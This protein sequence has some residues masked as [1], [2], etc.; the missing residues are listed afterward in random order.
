MCLQVLVS[1]SQHDHSIVASLS[2]PYIWVTIQCIW[3]LKAIEDKMAYIW[4]GVWEYNHAAQRFYG[5]NGFVK[6][7]SHQFMVGSD[8]Q[9]DFLMKKEL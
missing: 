3:Y 1:E 2:Y 9:I 4:L 5:R 7:G 6:V 8:V